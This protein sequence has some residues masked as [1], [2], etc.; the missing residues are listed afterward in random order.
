MHEDN[1]KFRSQCHEVLVAH[2]HAHH[3]SVLGRHKTE[4]SPVA[5]PTELQSLSCLLLGSLQEK[6]ADAGVHCSP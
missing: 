5:E 2:G 6:F 3:P 1:M 4:L